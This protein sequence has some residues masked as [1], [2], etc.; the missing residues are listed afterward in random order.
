MT[1]LKHTTI[2]RYTNKQILRHLDR[3]LSHQEAPALRITYDTIYQY[4]SSS[5]AYYPALS[6]HDR[7]DILEALNIAYTQHR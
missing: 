7:D 4:D 5:H 6:T 3:F 2:R 1:K